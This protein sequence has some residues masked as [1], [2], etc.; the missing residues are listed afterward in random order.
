VREDLAHIS[1]LLGCPILRDY[2]TSSNVEQD[3]ASE[4]NIALNVIERDSVGDVYYNADP[5]G[6]ALF[7]LTSGATGRRRLVMLTA[8]AIINRWWP[9]I[10]VAQ[11]ASAFFSWLPFDHIMGM[12]IAS[13]NLPAK[14]Y[15]PTG[16]FVASPAFWLDG[17]MQF[18]VTHSTMTNF[19]MSLI[20]RY[21]ASAP[22]RNWDLSSIRKIGIGAEDISPELC[23]RFFAAT[24]LGCAYS[25]VW[26]HR[27]RPGC[28]RQPSF[29]S[30]WHRHERPVCGAGPANTRAQ[31]A[32]C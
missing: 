13:P 6:P 11:E 9:S 16:Q 18:G 8:R 5:D 4:R 31:R 24:A 28:R 17:V 10:P 26:P 27:M 21:V 12:G 20:E 14:I 2:G 25:W 3:M 7:V 22:D 30:H 15:L 29:P 1:H 23:R 32:D 19:G